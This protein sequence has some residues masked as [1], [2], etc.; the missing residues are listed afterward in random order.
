MTDRIT[1]DAD[2][3]TELGTK[4]CAALRK[5]GKI[6]AVVYGHKQ[7]PVSLTV[8]KHDFV[9]GLH[10]GHRLFDVV[11]EGKSETLLV[12]DLQYDHLGKEVIHADL[13]RVDLTERV[14]VE[15]PVEFKGIAKGAAEG[16]MVDQNLD[17]LE[18]ECMVSEIPESIEVSIKEMNIG[19]VIHAED[20][21]LPEGVKLITDPKA[22]VALCHIVAAAAAEEE[23]PEEEVA[24][25]PEVIGERKEDEESEES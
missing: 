22:V 8:N 5:K 2:V 11:L 10:H 17:H 13:M 6:P 20:V 1:L 16:G 21:K 14:E 4:H 12:K 9:E 23:A 7:A 19:D 18:I 15:V 3:R 24:A 25:E